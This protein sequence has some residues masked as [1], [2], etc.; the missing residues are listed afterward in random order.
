MVAW[1]H[2][3]AGANFYND[4]AVGYGC[5]EEAAA[6]QDLHLTG[7]TE[8]AAAAV[9]NELVRGTARIGSETE[10]SGRVL[11]VS[12]LKTISVKALARGGRIEQL[13]ALRV[14]LG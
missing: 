4:L 7:R 12:G 13:E 11:R 5:A 8:E 14:I 6:I 1:W 9:P 2:G 10:V 3:G